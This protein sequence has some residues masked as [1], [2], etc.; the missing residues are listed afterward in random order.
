[1]KVY[2]KTLFLMIFV[3]ILTVPCHGKVRYNSSADSLKVLNLIE[4]ASKIENAGAKIVA[5]AEAM[6]GTPLGNPSDNDSIGTIVVRLD[7]MTRSE[8]VNIAL[9]VVKASSFSV[10]D[11]KNFEESLENLSRKKGR[12]EGFVSQFFYGADWLQDN[13][14]RGNLKEMTE[15]VDGS[16]FKTKSFDY[17]SRHRDQYP[18]LADS[19]NYEKIRAWEMGFRSHRLPYQKKHSIGNKAIQE[20]LQDGDIIMMLADNDTDLYDIGFVEMKDGQP[21]IIH[22]SRQKG[23]IVKDEFNLKRLFKL[24]GQ[25]FYGYRWIRPQ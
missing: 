9:A 25:F 21:Y 2:I 24:E 15:Y 11:I 17:V 19:V 16:I 20:L 18:A 5:T 8:F 4:I 23:V 6:T 14:N 1:M 12:D 3:T 22:F 7:S 10:L 13:I